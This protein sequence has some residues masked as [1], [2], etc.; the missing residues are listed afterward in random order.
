MCLS[1]IDTVVKLNVLMLQE[2]IMNRFNFVFVFVCI[3]AYKP[4]CVCEWVSEWVNVCMCMLIEQKI[5]DT[6]S[7]L[8]LTGN[9]LVH[10]IKNNLVVQMQGDMK[11]SYDF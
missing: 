11:S 7:C 9:M 10:L 6:E 1:A 2:C 3:Y 4:V 8:L 5:C